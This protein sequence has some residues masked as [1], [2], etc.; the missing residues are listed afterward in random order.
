MGKYTI[1]KSCK[2]TQTPSPLH[3][4]TPKELVE[5]KGKEVKGK[6]VKGGEGKWSKNP[7]NP[8]FRL[9]HLI[10]LHPPLGLHSLMLIG[11][12]STLVVLTTRRTVVSRVSFKHDNKMDFFNEGIQLITETTTTTHPPFFL[13]PV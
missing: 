8:F 13:R 4:F 6:E 3:P 10:A 2:I 7:T 11:T 9:T 12:P 1:R 5:V